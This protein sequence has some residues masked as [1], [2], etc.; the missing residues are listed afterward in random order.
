MS[1]SK[2][3]FF[4]G[5]SFAA[6]IF[7]ESA[8]NIP[9]GI[10]WALFVAAGLAYGFSWVTQRVPAYAGFFALLMLL[11]ILRMQLAEFSFQQDAL[12]SFH[13]QKVVV[14][15]TVVSD[16]DMRDS[17]QKMKVMVS[18]SLVLV[19]TARYPEYAYLDVVTLSGKIE[20]PGII[21][22]SG[23]EREFNYRNY[24][25]KDGIYSILFFPQVTLEGKAKGGISSA[26]YQM[27]VSVKE[28]LE[29]SISDIFNPPG[30]Q[31]MEGMLLGKNAQLPQ[32]LGEKLNVTGVRHLTAVSGSHVVILVAIMMSL[33]LFLG[34]WRTQA[35]YWALGLIWAY[36]ALI[37]FP[38]SGVRSAIMGSIFLAGQQW[39]RQNTSSRTLVLAGALMLA[40]NPFLLMYDIGFQLSFMASLGII[41]GKPLI[42]QLGGL[43]LKPL[44]AHKK[45]PKD[46]AEM[47][48][49]TLA[50]QVFTLP[51]LLY[52]FGNISWVAPITNALILPV[53]PLLM[54]FGFLAAI[55]GVFSSTLALIFAIP[56]QV[57]IAYFFLVV[58][59]FSQP[60][61]VSNFPSV[62]WAWM[63]VLYAVLALVTRLMYRRYSRYL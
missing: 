45:I 27:F 35:F 32:E 19:T 39:G 51:L 33:L 52:N 15:G 24:L 3:L 36:M 16:P 13:G 21:P 40:Q 22:A 1:I 17:S 12:V 37:G 53:V 11:G 49:V 30:S 28:K 54:Q 57:I 43:L 48:T 41:Y 47:V 58:D 34:F 42:D 5:I 46:L 44:P 7:L 26:I 56:T 63:V 60:W 55:T 14:T 8:G 31:L 18:G 10:S 59:F 61:A 20:D 62:H 25:L 23:T 9:L 50:A 2:I 6:G 4:C 29:Q 38:A